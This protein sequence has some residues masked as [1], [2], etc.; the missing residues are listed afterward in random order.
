MWPGGR[1]GTRHGNGES[2]VCAPQKLCGKSHSWWA[3][4]SVQG[5]EGG[6]RGGLG[7]MTWADR[8]GISLSTFFMKA[9]FP[10]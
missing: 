9:G 8:S 3:L 5:R 1:R 2:S 4:N 6:G 10:P 7:A